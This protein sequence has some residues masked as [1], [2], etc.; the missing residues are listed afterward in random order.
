MRDVTAI[1]LAAGLSRRMG[2]RNK[3]L[4]PVGGVPMIR[5]MVDVYSAATARPVLVVTG[6]EADD[7]AAAMADSQAMTVFNRDHAKGQATSVACG[8]RAANDAGAV[9]IGLGD[10][11]LLTTGDIRSL[12]GA[13]MS[14][15]R[16]RISIPAM[17]QRRGNPIVVPA[18]LRA[19]LLADPRSPGCKTFTRAHPEHVQ[20][21]ALAARGFYADIDTPEAY[22][23]LIA[24]RLEDT[25]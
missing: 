19:R 20:F 12:L 14:A 22:E 1:I 11:P 21:H 3:L 9:L 17:N 15:D 25:A 16:Q 4:L 13:H 8:L 24:R 2:G 5:H 23:T 10:Q 7:V 6:H 18:A